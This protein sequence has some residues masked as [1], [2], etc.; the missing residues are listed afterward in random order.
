MALVKA[1]EA[2]VTTQPRVI[3]TACAGEEVRARMINKVC[4]P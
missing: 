3:V 2:K 4:I 1:I